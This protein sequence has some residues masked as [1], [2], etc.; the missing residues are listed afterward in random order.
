MSRKVHLAGGY[1]TYADYGDEIQTR[2]W[3]ESYTQR[4]F[5]VALLH[6]AAPEQASGFRHDFGEHAALIYHHSVLRNKTTVKAQDVS[7]L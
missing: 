4:A 5:H 1:F 3:I 7:L 2:A 6:A